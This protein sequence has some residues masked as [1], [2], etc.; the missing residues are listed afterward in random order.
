MELASG[1]LQTPLGNFHAHTSYPLS[2][3]GQLAGYRHIGKTAS[4]AAHSAGD[5]HA[6]ASATYG[7][8]KVTTHGSISSGA[9]NGGAQAKFSD[10]LKLENAALTGK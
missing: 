1:W 2:K 6:T 9:S 8:L 5:T 7:V 3:A 4:A 10:T